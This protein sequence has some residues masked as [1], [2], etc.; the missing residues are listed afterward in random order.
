[1]LLVGAFELLA[2]GGGVGKESETGRGL[3]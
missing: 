3:L 1:V 2:A